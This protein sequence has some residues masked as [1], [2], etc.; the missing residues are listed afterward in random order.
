MDGISNV[1]LGL[2][3]GAADV[4][5]VPS[6]QESFGQTGSEAQAC[7]RP[8]VAFDCT[9]LRGVVQHLATGY[10]VEPFNVEGL[11]AWLMAFRIY[12]TMMPG[13]STWEG[14]HGSAPC[15]SGRHRS[16]CHNI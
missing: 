12:W 15:V 3:Y 4:M 16:W 7:G 10:L 6:L 2:L 8:V 14:S 1:A 13:G 9:G 5:V 11:A